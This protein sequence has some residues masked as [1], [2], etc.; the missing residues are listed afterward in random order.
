MD[1]PQPPSHQHQHH[2]ATIVER[3]IRSRVALSVFFRGADGVR[4]RTAVGLST[5]VVV[6]HRIGAM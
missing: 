5:I 6:E 4:R 1:E 2:A 3:R